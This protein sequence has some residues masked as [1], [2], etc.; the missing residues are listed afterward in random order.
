MSP[1]DF[2]R[3]VAA[4]LSTDQIAVVMEIMDREA[5]AFA[6]ANENRKAKAR[7]RVAR[8]REKHYSDVTETSPKVTERLTGAGARVEDKT[9][10][11]KIEPQEENK[12]RGSRDVSEFRAA[13]PDLDAERLD[14]LVKLRK[15]K[16]GQLTGHAA[17][18]FRRDAADC[19][20]GIS[21]AVDTCISRNWIT[22]K[23]EWLADR[24]GVGPPP[25]KPNPALDVAR[26]LMDK[27]D[28]V[29][30]SETQGNSAYP[31][32]VAVAG[33]G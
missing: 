5:K 7:E 14:A 27:L 31:R 11:Q 28:A 1:D 22:V 6:E 21:E 20:L 15:V 3:L 2:K 32:L 4:G 17:R 24:R 12:T 26:Q 8:W 13:F 23:P 29:T 25:A 33:G 19:G 16:R 18:L 10:T 9:S 30:P